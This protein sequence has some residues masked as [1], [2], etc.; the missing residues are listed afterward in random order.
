MNHSHM[1]Q[2]APGQKQDEKEIIEWNKT[3][4]QWQNNNKRC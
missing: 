4:A 1:E 2:L 3:V